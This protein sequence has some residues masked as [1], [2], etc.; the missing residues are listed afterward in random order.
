MI[1]KIK[2]EEMK[3]GNSNL[4]LACRNF[5]INDKLT[6]PKLS[7]HKMQGSITNFNINRR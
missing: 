7:S 6:T 4:I 5:P 1:F 3:R 2:I